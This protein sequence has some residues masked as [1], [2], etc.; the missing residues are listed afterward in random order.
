MEVVKEFTL[1]LIERIEIQRFGGDGIF[2]VCHDGSI[3]D[4]VGGFER[5]G[6]EGV[7]IGN[8]GGTGVGRHC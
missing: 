3:D 7:I 6:L 2:F 4:L 5:D 8:F 1:D